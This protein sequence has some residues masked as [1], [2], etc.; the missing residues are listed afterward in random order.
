MTQAFWIPLDELQPSQLYV[1]QIKLDRVMRWFDPAH[2]ER[3]E[4]LPVKDLGGYVVLTDGHARALA[5]YLHHCETIPVSWNTDSLDWEAYAICVR[6]CQEA[7]IWMIADLEDQ[8]LPA[9]EYEVQ[10]IERCRVM[11]QGL[12]ARRA[13]A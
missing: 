5:A 12:A 4:P 9:E 8:V 1:S 13:S 2:M 6:W 11:F 3:V 10:W 7:G